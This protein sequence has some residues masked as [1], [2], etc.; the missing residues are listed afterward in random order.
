M[1]RVSL[2]WLGVGAALTAVLTLTACGGSTDTP[3]A[4]GSTTTTVAAPT[5]TAAPAL[6]TSTAPTT[7]TAAPT[8]TTTAASTTLTDVQFQRNESYFFSSPDGTFT[9][10]IVR[11]PNRTEA[12]CEGATTPVPPRPD[13][14]MVSWG[15]GIRVENA[16]RGAFMC[17]GGQVYT[18]GAGTEPVLAPGTPLAKLGYTCGTTASSVTCTNDETGHGFTVAPDSN[19]TF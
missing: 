3:A 8:T 6:T 13:D 7:T 9:C 14:C 19:E 1:R 11:L 17:S 2:P 12:G 4:A 10:G 5:T 16:G 18:S 15:N